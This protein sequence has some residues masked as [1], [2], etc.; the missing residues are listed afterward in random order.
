MAGRGSD[1]TAIVA[2]CWI[3]GIVLTFGK[4][5]LA[6]LLAPLVIVSAAYVAVDVIRGINWMASRVMGD[7]S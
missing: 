2:S 7:A 1:L 5:G 4:P 3:A 6:I